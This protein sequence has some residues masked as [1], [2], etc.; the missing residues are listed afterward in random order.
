MGGFFYLLLLCSRAHS[1]ARCPLPPACLRDVRC[2]HP[3]RMAP[4]LGVVWVRSRSGNLGSVSTIWTR[5]SSI[6][7]K[8]IVTLSASLCKVAS[9][10]YIYLSH[11]NIQ[12]TKLLSSCPQPIHHHHRH[13]ANSHRSS[14]ELAGMIDG[15]RRDQDRVLKDIRTSSSASPAS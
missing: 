4:L 5:G 9:W 14:D 13:H 15:R 11:S 12:S 7:K 6:R 1:H 2:M 3:R 10:N 8:Y